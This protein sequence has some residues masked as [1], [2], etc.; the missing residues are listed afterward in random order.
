MSVAT[1]LVSALAG[2]LSLTTEWLL[3]GASALLIIANGLRLLTSGDT[4]TPVHVGPSVPAA[5][6]AAR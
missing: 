2:W 4:G 5:V 3:N 6:G 1:L